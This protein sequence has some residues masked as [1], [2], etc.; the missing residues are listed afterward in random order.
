MNIG[1]FTDE[2]MAREMNVSTS[3]LKNKRKDTEKVHLKNYAWSRDKKGKLYYVYNLLDSDLIAY[4]DTFEAI[5]CNLN[6]LEIN[7]GNKE[8]ALKILMAINEAESSRVSILTEKTGYYTK[9]VTRYVN[10]FKE[11]EILTS[12]TEIVEYEYYIVASKAPWKLISKEEAQAYKDQWSRETKKAFRVAN[13]GPES[14]D[15]SKTDICINIAQNAVYETFGGYL[16]K[17]QKKELTQEAKD[18]LEPFFK[19]IQLKSQLVK[20]F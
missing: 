18:M 16:K 2:E 7:L 10:K 5:I 12:G 15:K 14:T 11:M 6:Y 1:I 19:Y 4:L 9:E 20:Q 17:V 8:K 3:T 13:L